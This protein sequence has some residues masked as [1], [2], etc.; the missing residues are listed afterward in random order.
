MVKLHQDLIQQNVP[1]VWFAEVQADLE[2]AF[3]KIT[4]GLVA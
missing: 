3:M 1:L 2:E 4:K